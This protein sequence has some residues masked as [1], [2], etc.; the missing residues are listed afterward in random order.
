MIVVV[1]DPPGTWSMK[2]VCV[3][4]VSGPRSTTKLPQPT[5]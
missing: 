3:P 5:E 2:I 1:A 4:G